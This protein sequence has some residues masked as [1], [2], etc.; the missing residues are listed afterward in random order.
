LERGE[1]G[2][3][4][5]RFVVRSFSFEQSSLRVESRQND[6]MTVDYGDV[7]LILCGK[8][9][10]T[11]TESSTETSTK[12][13]LGRAVMTSGLVMTKKEEKHHEHVTENRE[14]FIHLIVKQNKTI[15]FRENDLDYSSLGDAMKP[16]R[17]ANFTYIAAELR[18]RCHNVTYDDSLLNKNVQMQILGP[19]FD[20]E[21]H[22]DIAIDL[23]AK[24][25]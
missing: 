17:Y 5:D 19:L 4:G 23:L 16:T 6:E 8:G 9:I 1:G 21:E 18:K 7:S 3:Q 22:L 12:F 15:V 14:G 10:M 13:S 20:P 24:I 25:K 2:A 11:E